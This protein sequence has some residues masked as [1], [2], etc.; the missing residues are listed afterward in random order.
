MEESNII[1]ERPQGIWVGKESLR[2]GHVCYTVYVS[3]VC[4]SVADSSYAD[5]MT[6]IER[7]NYLDKRRPTRDDVI[8]LHNTIAMFNRMQ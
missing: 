4:S 3:G 5:E 1:F 8:E 2:H 6:A 7:A